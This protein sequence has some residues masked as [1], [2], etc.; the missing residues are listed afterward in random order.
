MAKYLL[1]VNYNL[2][3]IRGVAAK[4]GSAREKAATDAVESVG[5]TVDS[6]FFAFGDTDVVVI[7]DFPDTISAAALAVAVGAGGGAT[8][9]TTVLLTAKDV[10]KAAKK[11]V[12]YHP[13][14]S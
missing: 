3:G 4:G 9:R 2:D 13:P 8:V 10:D 6:F 1:Q 7:A 11:Q 14:G 12:T 5:G